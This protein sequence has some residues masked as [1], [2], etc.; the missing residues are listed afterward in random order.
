M[1]HKTRAF[2]IAASLLLV[3]ACNGTGLPVAPTNTPQSGNE[4][5]ATPTAESLASLPT[6]TPRNQTRPTRTPRG[7]QP[8]EE[9]TEVATAEPTEDAGPQPTAQAIDPELDREVRQVEEDT[10]AVRGLEPKGDVPETFLTQSQ[11]KGNL[12]RD[13]SEDY[14]QE[15]ADQDTMELWLLRL[16][17]DPELDMLQLQIDLLGE[18]VLG[19]YDPEKDEMYVLRNQ[20]DL[21]PGSKQ[22]LAHEFV[23]AL[24][25]QHFDLE[26]LL[27]E[28]SHDDDRS[29]AIRA[30][31]EGDATMAGLSY[32]RDY[33]SQAEIEEFLEESSSADTS[34]LNSAPAYLRE[35]LYF[36]YDAGADFVNELLMMGGFQA[37]DE[38]LADPPAS[39]EQILHPDKYFDSPRDEPIQVPLPP[40]TD[41][42]GAGWTMVDWGTLGEFDLRVILDENS[43]ADPDEAAAGWGGGSYAFYQSPD[44]ALGLMYTAIDWDDQNESDEYFDALEET[45]DNATRTGDLY[46]QD[47]RFYSLT[48]S[49][50]TV[51]LI[52]SNDQAA[53]ES[54][55]K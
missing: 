40:L 27:P 36:P 28:D 15:E 22:T 54:V 23:H 29:L 14:T 43:A 8:T 42:L 20:S 25:D 52:S 16:V 6:A 24:Q 47:G 30:V 48:R 21:S 37:V 5:A 4:S 1:R 45:F 46:E 13:I 49:G 18:Q 53:L 31:V 3:T 32:V 12:L 19:Y 11:M 34:V 7:A 35:S 44:R 39:T 17:D 2:L 55:A 38:A 9:P 51:T 10:S 41:T 33:F 26:K 50:K